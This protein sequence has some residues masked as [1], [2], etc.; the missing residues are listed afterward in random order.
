[1]GKE[2]VLFVIIIVQLSKMLKSNWSSLQVRM[3]GSRLGVPRD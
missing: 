3:N 1:M 2:W